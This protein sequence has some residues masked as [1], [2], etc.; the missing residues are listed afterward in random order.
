MQTN[1]KEL[2]D[3]IKYL[4][5][6]YKN[7]NVFYHGWVSKKE[8]NESWKSADVWFYP[9]VFEETFCLTAYEAAASKTLAITTEL[10]GLKTT[11]GNRGILLSCGPMDEE[12]ENNAINT[13]FKVL[14]S[15]EKNALIEQNYQWITMRSWKDQANKMETILLSNK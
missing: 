15:A 2:M 11:V 14:H 10:A 13:V 6:Q 3:K 4:I 5:D 9:C 7:K 1:F 12:W 8:L